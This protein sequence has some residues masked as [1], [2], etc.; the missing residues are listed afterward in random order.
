MRIK[1]CAWFA[2]A[3]GFFIL[4]LTLLI[5]ASQIINAQYVKE[6]IIAL[7]SRKIGPGFNFQSADVSLFPVPRVLIRKAVYSYPEKAKGEAEIINIYPQLIPLLSGN[8]RIAKVQIE[9][10]VFFFDLSG[11]GKPHAAEEMLKEIFQVLNAQLSEETGLVVVIKKGSAN[12]AGDRKELLPLRHLESRFV[13]SPGKLRLSISGS[14]DLLKKFSLTGLMHK[15]GSSPAEVN[16]SLEARNVDAVS[17]RDAAF[18]LVGDDRL[19]HDIFAVVRGGNVSSITLQGHGLSPSDLGNYENILVRG[20]M[21]EGEIFVPGPELT[22]RGVNGKFLISKG[23]LQ[24]EDIAAVLGHAALKN[25]KV[26]IGLVGKGAP[27]HLEGDAKF[28]IVELYPMVQRALKAEPLVGGRNAAQLSKVNAIARFVIDASSDEMRFRA[29]GSADFVKKFSLRGEMGKRG[30]TLSDIALDFEAGKIDIPSARNAAFSLFGDA[31]LVSNIFNIL[32]GGAVPYLNFHSQGASIADVGKA[33]NMVI[34]GRLQGGEI[35]IPAPEL[36][37]R[38]VTG[39]C[40]IAK[41]IL[42]GE[43]ISAR[44]EHASLKNGELTIGLQG[45]DAPMHLETFAQLN[46]PE[47]YHIVQRAFK[48]G[49][50]PRGLN[51]LQHVKGDAEG[52]LIWGESL[53]QLENV[54]F[55]GEIRTVNGQLVPLDF[56]NTEKGFQMRTL[57]INDAF[58]RATFT[59]NLEESIADFSFEGMLRKKS[60]EALIDTSSFPEGIIQGKFAAHLNLK[61]PL[62]ITAQGNL[63]GE[64]ILIPWG[65]GLFITIE[66][67]SVQAAANRMTVQSAVLRIDDTPVSLR[68]T[69]DSSAEGIIMDADAFVERLA[70]ETVRKMLVRGQKEGKTQDKKGGENLPVSGSLR[71]RLNNF[72]YEGF[73]VSPL[74]ADIS[75]FPDVV[76]VAVTRAS[77]CGIALPGNV[78]VFFDETVQIDFKLLARAQQLQPAFACVTKNKKMLL[79]GLYDFDALLKA[80]GNGEHILQSLNGKIDFSAKDGRIYRSVG[81]AKIF[82]VINIEGIFEGGLPDLVKEGFAYRSFV[83]KGEINKGKIIVKEAI[84]DSPSMEL[85][86]EGTIDLVT[87]KIDMKV[88]AAPLKPVDVILRNIPLVKNISGHNFVSVPVTIKGDLD[89]P[90]VSSLSASSVGSAILGIMEKILKAPVHLF[91]PAD[92]NK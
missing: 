38:A 5:F 72:M 2:G 3:G 22:F 24:G 14:S 67:V 7:V 60:L 31:P 23:V 77:V 55:R 82:S 47:L 18:S 61:R 51:L 88:L 53:N 44:L 37:F 58:S 10:P 91:F 11:Q 45:R 19:M 85:V 8:I 57:A 76:A 52:S 64:K 21:Q 16:L 79:T 84:I 25:G 54:A 32:R 26:T 69:F 81:L 33:E 29:G 56:L 63:K 92:D 65:K 50:L 34:K 13:F 12:L 4:L 75:F 42:K 30:A 48:N 35:F 15:T 39:D 28:N 78:R 17:A 68:G 9:S 83:V 62:E 36:T 71:V 80:R 40:V 41:G 6:K 1:Q 46:V 20:Q 49:V 89:D 90:E 87:K 74:F 59:L 66:N 43:H 86:G 73:T 70:W 27:L